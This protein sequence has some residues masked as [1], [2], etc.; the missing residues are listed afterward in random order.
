[1][2]RTYKATINDNGSNITSGD[3]NEIKEW[4]SRATMTFQ[5]DLTICVVEILETEMTL[6]ASYATGEVEVVA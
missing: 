5:R 2:S 4:A 1:M 3:L 6:A